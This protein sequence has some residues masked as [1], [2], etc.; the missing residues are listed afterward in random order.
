[1]P[2]FFPAFNTSFASLISAIEVIIDEISDLWI[3]LKESEIKKCRKCGF[4]GV[5]SSMAEGTT[6]A[7]RER[8]VY[9]FCSVEQNL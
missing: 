4:L 8:W 3:H 6:Q 9:V 1:M 2:T 5:S 7:A